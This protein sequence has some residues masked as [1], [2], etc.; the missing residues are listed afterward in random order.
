M[1]QL[2]ATNDAFRPNQT[3]TINSMWA[4]RR[5]DYLLYDKRTNTEVTKNN[6]QTEISTHR[7]GKFLVSP[8]ASSS[9]GLTIANRFIKY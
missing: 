5:L 7:D 4:S 9:D 3:S 6:A 8:T 2:M 1:G